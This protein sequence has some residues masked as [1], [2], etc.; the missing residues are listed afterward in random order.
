MVQEALETLSDPEL[1]KKY[2]RRLASSQVRRKQSAEATGPSGK[3]EEAKTSSSCPSTSATQKPCSSKKRPRDAGNKGKS[4]SLESRQQQLLIKVHDLLKQLPRE[5]RNDVLKTKFSEKQ[6]LILE[7][8]IVDTT[9]VESPPVPVEAQPPSRVDTAKDVS[10]NRFPRHLVPFQDP[11]GSFHIRLKLQRQSVVSR[12]KSQVKKKRGKRTR[13][14]CGSIQKGWQGYVS[15]IIFDC[16][17]IRSG[18]SDLQTALEHLMILTTAKQKYVQGS[19][20]STFEERLE[21]SLKSSADEHGKQVKELDLRFAVVQPAAFFVGYQRPV[22][23]PTV[24]SI[25]ALGRHRNSL[26]PFRQYSIKSKQRRSQI[27]WFFS[28]SHL[29]DTWQRFQNTVN[30]MWRDS[31]PSYLQRIC[32]SREASLASRQRMLQWWEREHMAL[33]DENRHRPKYLQ[34]KA[35]KQQKHREREQMAKHDKNQHRPCRLRIYTP[36]EIMT[37]PPIVVFKHKFFSCF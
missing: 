20:D 9:R 26:A 30:E 10:K 4:L 13:R 5:A 14:T 29:E 6:R 27:F 31:D 28:P 19:E 24:R 32:I 37:R 7:K 33:Q 36:E 18:Q 12:S 17:Q 3:K 15:T 25:Q 22:R 34:E 11:T 2:D 16:I 21:R 23:S 8:W 1:R 35:T